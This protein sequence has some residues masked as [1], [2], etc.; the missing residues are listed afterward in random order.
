MNEA[1]S[2]NSAGMLNVLTAGRVHMPPLAHLG[3]ERNAH[4]LPQE[5][6]RQNLQVRLVT[7][8]TEIWK[9][10]WCTSKAHV[11]LLQ[12]LMLLHGPCLAK[13]LPG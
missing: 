10:S 9:Y 2:A 5:M 12:D 6:R 8:H 13:K 4:I 3:R 7:G 1:S 11:K